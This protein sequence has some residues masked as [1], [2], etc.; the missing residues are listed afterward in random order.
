M[1]LFTEKF[2]GPKLLKSFLFSSMLLWVQL[3][4]VYTLSRTNAA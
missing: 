4:Y 2:D 1:T 3:F